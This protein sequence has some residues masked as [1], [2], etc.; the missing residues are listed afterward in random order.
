MSARVTRA[1]QNDD[2]DDLQDMIAYG[3]SIDF[4]LDTPAGSDPDLLQFSPP[5]VSLAAFYGAEKCFR[6]LLVNGANFE[7]VDSVSSSFTNPFSHHSSNDRSF[8]GRRRRSVDHLLLERTGHQ[9]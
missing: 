7:L 3:L 6:Y 8:R 4:I 9:F 2:V 5:L 1:V